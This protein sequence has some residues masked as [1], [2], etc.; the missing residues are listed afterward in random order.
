[1]LRLRWAGPIA[2]SSKRAGRGSGFTLVELLVVVAIIGILIALLLPATQAAREA[3]RRAQC[4]NNLKQIGLASVQYERTHGRYANYSGAPR[5][6]PYAVLT[7][8]TWIVA[9]MPQL[10]ETALYATWARAAG[11][12]TSANPPLAATAVVALVATPI[13]VL[14]CPTRRPAQAFEVMA[15]DA[16][17]F[18]GYPVSITKAVRSDYAL[19]GGADAV[20]TDTGPNPMV[21]LPGI[22]EAAT[23]AAKA[24]KGVRVK[25]ITDGL[26]KTYLA[27]EKSIPIDAY[28][29]GHFWGDVSSIYSCPLGDCVRFAEQPP[30]H[31]PPTYTDKNKSC[32]ACHSFGSS[33]SSTWNAVYCDGSVHALALN[34]SFK[35][36][37]AMASRAAGDTAN[38]REN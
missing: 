9:I 16:I 33:H 18:P 28:E 23:S 29:N 35:T 13:K 22:W 3:A 24:A 38:P 4:L 7:T 20:P 30:G 10:E 14:N 15:K 26:S 19:N 11:Y 31:D 37:K 36:H 25:E 12:G 27:A 1:M 5:P 8:P 34:M 32:W 17:Q 6:N 21:G 2:P